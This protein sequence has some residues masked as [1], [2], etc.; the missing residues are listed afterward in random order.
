[1]KF[2]PKLKYKID[3]YYVKHPVLTGYIVRLALSVLALFLL[4]DNI[5]FN[6]ILSN[7]IFVIAFALICSFIPVKLMT[8]AL[9]AYAIVH[10]FSLSVGVGVLSCLLFVVL[11]LIY[12]RFDE[13]TGYVIILIPLLCMLRL[14]FL[15]PVILA[16]AAPL[17]SVASVILGFV[18]YYYLHYIQMNTAVFIGAVDTSEISKMSMALQGL[19]AYKEM[20]Y[21][22]G[23]VLVAFLAAYYL[24]KINVNRSGHMA[25]AIGTGIWLILTLLCNLVTESMNYNKLIWYVGGAV[26]TIILGMIISDLVLP[27]D[28]SRTELLEFEDDEYKYFVRAVP[29]AVVTKESVKI[30]R[31][32]SR[33]RT[34]GK[35]NQESRKNREDN[36]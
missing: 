22:M 14:P 34:D 33:K 18:A 12:F 13:K 20:W 10:L 21:T 2:L 17:G 16:V 4:R 28:F 9:V 29:K 7:T 30:K 6:E 19:F 31:I 23:C 27:L 3:E 26:A 24:K 11:Y 15:A 32:Y 1:M 25:V 36:P 5:G 35:K 8:L